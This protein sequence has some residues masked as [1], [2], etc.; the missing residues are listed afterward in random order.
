MFVDCF[1]VVRPC[2]LTSSGSRGSAAATRF[3]TS[4]VAMSTS[5]PTSNVT[6]T[7]IEPSSELVDER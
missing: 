3:C 1:R 6:V 5:T 2:R 7:P 4:T